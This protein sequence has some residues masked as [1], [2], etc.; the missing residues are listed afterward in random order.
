MRNLD[1]AIKKTQKRLMQLEKRKIK[2]Y[3][4]IK[5]VDITPSDIGRAMLDVMKRNA[6]SNELIKKLGE[7]MLDGVKDIYGNPCVIKPL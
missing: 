1:K 5:R 3:A 2:N 4:N 6:E 7:V